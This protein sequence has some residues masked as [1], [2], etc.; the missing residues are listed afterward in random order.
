MRS[1]PAGSRGACPALDGVG[2]RLLRHR[3]VREL[4]C[5][6]RVRATRSRDTADARRGSDGRGRLHR[7]GYNPQRRHSSLDYESP[8]G[9]KA[10][11]DATPLG[12]V[13]R[14]IHEGVARLHLHH[15]G[16][17]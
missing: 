2:R 4:L 8:L 1:R 17:I 3:D 13:P 12:R 16:V 6:A 14:P 15:F 11:H 9:F 7:G 5:D 10:R